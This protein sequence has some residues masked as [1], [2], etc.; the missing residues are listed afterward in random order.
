MG[1][2]LRAAARPFSLSPG[3]LHSSLITPRFMRVVSH[4]LL[5]LV[6]MADER[7]IIEV[8]SPFPVRELP[9]VWL[10]ME[11]VLKYVA[12]DDSPRTM[13]AYVDYQ[14]ERLE[15]SITWGVYRDGILGGFISFEPIN[16]QAG[17][18]HTIFNR[19]THRRDSFFGR[20]T[21]VPALTMA[22]LQLFTIGI[23]QIVMTPFEDNAA[24]L[25]LLQYIGA[26]KRALWFDAATRGG[27]PV[28]L[29]HLTL[30]P[31]S[32]IL[33]DEYLSAVADES[34]AVAL[35]AVPVAGINGGQGDDR[36]ADRA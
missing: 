5:W 36:A 27:Q 29:V 7:P 10:W 9:R 16:E 18:A 25:A 32:L 31:D 12:N 26:R 2:W 4:S 1:G 3:V 11:P 33:R 22:A 24:I 30:S 21:T 6:Y 28:N 17:M 13:E 35:D 14:L 15:N 19:G 20:K 34:P 23:E 8:R